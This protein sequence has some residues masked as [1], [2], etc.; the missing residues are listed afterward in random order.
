MWLLPKEGTKPGKSGE[1]KSTDMTSD[2]M[3]MT[4]F[5]LMSFTDSHV[6][7]QCIE[8]LLA[9]VILKGKD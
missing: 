5:L 6:L 4:C 9:V 3:L 1:K 7:F 2:S 8:E